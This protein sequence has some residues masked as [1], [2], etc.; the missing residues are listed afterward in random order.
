V[1]ECL[2]KHVI[3]AAIWSNFEELQDLSHGGV[4]LHG[5]D[6]LSFRILS[7]LHSGFVPSSNSKESVET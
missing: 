1:Q 4:A 3:I 6:E 2:S 7:Q 5:L